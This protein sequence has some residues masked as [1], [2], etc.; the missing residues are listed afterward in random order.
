MENLEWLMGVS[1]ASL[2]LGFGQGY[3]FNQ[4]TE[5]KGD[6]SNLVTEL[7][8]EFFGDEVDSN[9]KSVPKIKKKYF[10]NELL[11]VADGLAVKILADD[12]TLGFGLTSGMSFY[13]GTLIGRGFSEFKRSKISLTKDEQNRVDSLVGSFKNYTK[14]NG[15]APQNAGWYDAELRSVSDY[16]INKKNP[17]LL[18]KFTYDLTTAMDEGRFYHLAENLV[19]QVSAKPDHAG[20]AF[21]TS[22]GERDVESLI[23]SG[24]DLYS[25]TYAIPNIFGDLPNDISPLFKNFMSGVMTLDVATEKLDWGGDLDYIAKRISS[26]YK[27]TDVVLSLVPKDVPIADASMKTYFMYKAHKEGNVMSGDLSN[28]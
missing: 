24:D 16:L 23:I 15:N 7:S 8:S 6:V 27:F 13:L 14:L 18:K 11:A 5:Y 22:E 4:R 28:N 12:R 9:S 2:G 3:N 26:K 1:I 19:K 20:L 10:V 17:E 21:V 25:V